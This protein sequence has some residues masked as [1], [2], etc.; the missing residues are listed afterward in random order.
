MR[1]TLK[2]LLSSTF[3]SLAIAQA[4]GA[5]VKSEPNKALPQLSAEAIVEKNVSARGG[6]AAWRAVQ[7]LSMSGKMDA[8]GN[9]SP[10]RRPVQ[11]VRTSG[12]QLPKR[13]A[14]QMQLPF[15][16]ELKRTRKSRLELDF[17]GQTAIQ[18]YDGANGWKLRP[19]LNRRQVEPFGPDELKAVAMQSDLDGPLVDYAAKGTKVELEGTEKVEGNDTY[20]LKLTFKNGQVQR[21]WV[22][23]KTFLETRLEGTPRR[24]DGKYHAVEIYLRDYRTVSGLIVPY[25]METKVEGVKQ[26]EKIEVEKVAVNPR[27]EDARFAKLQ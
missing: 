7:T 5:D 24:L 14:E 25:V 8:G 27:V 13:P 12:V 9:E 2:V 10:T 21:V 23:A 17:R 18:V 16:L 4:V 3:L 15:R 1:I 11:G 20:R 22:D 26:S 19:F 6:L